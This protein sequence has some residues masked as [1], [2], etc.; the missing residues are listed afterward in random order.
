MSYV[1]AL[2][3]HP[4][5]MKCGYMLGTPH[6]GDV[7]WASAAAL[8]S[9]P[10]FPHGGQGRPSGMT[11][12]GAPCD[13]PAQKTLTKAREEK[14]AILGSQGGNPM[15]SGLA[16]TTHL[17]TNTHA[18]SFTRDSASHLGLDEDQWALED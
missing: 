17:S 7:S 15:Q 8:D 13:M 11:F 10:G 2:L 12:P 6:S 1:S 4:P 16:R 18:A 3:L 9:L 14:E 5:K